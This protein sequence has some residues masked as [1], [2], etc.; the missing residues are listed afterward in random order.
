MNDNI[1][2][3]VAKLE[4]Q[5]SP[6]YPIISLKNALEKAQ[7]IWDKAARHEVPIQSLADY[8]EISKTSSSLIGYSA[9]LVKYG[10]LEYLSGQGRDKQV[11]LTQLAIEA[12]NHPVGSKERESALKKAALNPEIYKEIWEKYQGQLPD[13]SVIKPYLLIQKHFNNSYVN[14]FLADFRESISV[15]NLDSSDIS[16]IRPLSEA[17]VVTTTSQP[18]S[19]LNIVKSS[20]STVIR[21]LPI[22]LDGGLSARI[23]YPISEEDF[24]ILLETLELWKK[25]IVRQDAKA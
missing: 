7:K 16:S 4:K 21:E 6:K 17:S 18:N 20:D 11:R 13:D 2:N 10:L 3:K 5:R 8:W 24:K 9:A 14:G 22:P 25:R 12:I 15:A 1:A 19:N 23:P